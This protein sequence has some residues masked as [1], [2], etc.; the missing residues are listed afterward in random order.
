MRN[1]ICASL[2]RLWKEKIFWAALAFMAAAGIFFTVIQHIAQQPYRDPAYPITPEGFCFN[3]HQLIGVASAMV[4]C[5]FLGRE[6]QDG[7]L[8][9]KLI[10]GYPRWK[11]YLSGLTVNAAAS[12]LLALGYSLAACLCGMPVFGGFVVSPGEVLLLILSCVLYVAVYASLFTMI[13]MLSGSRAAAVVLCILLALGLYVCSE[14]IFNVFYEPA[15]RDYLYN[16]NYPGDTVRGCL[17]VLYEFLPT[18]QGRLL[19]E[20]TQ[21]AYLPIKNVPYGLLPLYSLAL[22]AFTTGGGLLGF[23]NKRIS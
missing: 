21:A 14:A 4:C 20:Y 8:R 9:N 23:Q 22:I 10:A 13:Q 19:T 15:V 16:P 5:L 6:F 17:E 12:V 7:A 3:F 11:V 1:L 18:G 2:S